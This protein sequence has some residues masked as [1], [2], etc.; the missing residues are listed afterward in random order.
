MYFVFLTLFVQVESSGLTSAYY[1]L[2]AYRI[3]SAKW[4][5]CFSHGK[6]PYSCVEG[7]ERFYTMFSRADMTSSDARKDV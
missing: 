4:V 5:G 7:P 2:W 1:A 3:A 6:R